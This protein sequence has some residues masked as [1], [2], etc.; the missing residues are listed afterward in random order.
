MGSQG[1]EVIGFTDAREIA[2]GRFLLSGLLNGLSGTDDLSALGAPSGAR[3]VL[4]GPAAVSLALGETELGKT[5]SARLAASGALGG[6]AG[7]FTFSGGLRA[8]RPLS[9]VHPAA[10][11]LSTGDIVFSWIR[12]G[13]IDADGWEARDI[14]LDE[15]E[16]R[17]RL[18]LSGSDGSIRR[19]FTVTTPSARYAAADEKTDFGTRQAFFDITL[20]QIGRRVPDGIPLTARLFL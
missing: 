5:L 11:R 17:Y 20:R 6:I 16:E 3:T 10:R 9:P 13:R 18:D 15:A 4:L 8:E 19:S 2:P 1:V 7:P 14:P 12:R